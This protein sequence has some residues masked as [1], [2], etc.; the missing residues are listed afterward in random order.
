[1]LI[2]IIFF[3]NMK[4]SSRRKFLQT[5]SIGAAAVMS[6]SI[7]ARP[8]K[9]NVSNLP[10]DLTILF[11]GNSITDAGR[12]KSRYYANDS[13][14][15]GRGYVYQIV[16]QL[17]GE[18]PSKNWE[19]YNRGI[20]GNK[21]FQ[22]ENRWK[23]DCLQLNPDVLSI[24]I[25]VNDFWHS[26]NNYNGT[27]E[28]YEKD[29]R[30]LMKKTQHNLPDLKLIVGEPFAVTGGTAI[31]ERWY[32]GFEAYQKVAKKIAQEFNAVFIPFQNVF[33]KALEVAPA[34]YWCPDG[35]H[36]SM[37]GAYL[38]KEAWIEGFNELFN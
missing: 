2:H 28:I 4:S 31:D 6:H 32:P 21:V 8:A 11:Q 23:E 29:F 35:V 26:L 15:M 30:E 25:G 37:A 22:L 13:L 9:L 3:L 14:G 36:P 16:A 19:Y 12:D 17:Q 5:G 18:N 24:L 7:F 38:M 10:E 1:M 27:V 33:D 20:S 34:S